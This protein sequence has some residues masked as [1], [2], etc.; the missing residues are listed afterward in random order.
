MEGG[1]SNMSTPSGNVKIGGRIQIILLK[2]VNIK[3]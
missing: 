1:H 2:C 3:R